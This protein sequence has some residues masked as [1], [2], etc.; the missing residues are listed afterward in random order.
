M[1]RQFLGLERRATRG[2]RDT[3]DHPRGGHDDVSNAV[4]GALVH[5][6]LVP[7]ATT[8]PNFWNRKIQ[9]DDRGLV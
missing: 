7:T 6:K 8:S 3:V 5:A 1:K 9:Y 4:A 2:G